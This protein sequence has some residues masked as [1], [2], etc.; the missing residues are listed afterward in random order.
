MKKNTLYEILEVSENASQEIIERAYKTLAKRY[1]PD[2]QENKD[3]KKAEEMMK[4]INQAY[5]V[6]G[7]RVRREE[8]D[9]ELQAKRE[10][11]QKEQLEKQ[12][13]Q[14][15]REYNNQN[16]YS[17][18]KQ[19]EQKTEKQDNAEEQVFKTFGEYFKY[20]WSVIKTKWRE[21]YKDL[22]ITI[23]IIIIILVILWAMPPVRNSLTEFYEENPFFR[24][25]V[26]VVVGIARGI[27]NFIVRLFSW[28]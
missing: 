1:H 11:M 20:I 16:K 17:N 19:P 7:D 22:F 5:D 12:K 14:I 25:I 23:V 26:N 15:Y 21:N 24:A 13:Q 18:N 6:L 10:Q 8:Y 28:N 3:K 4:K 9:K 2:L 27:W